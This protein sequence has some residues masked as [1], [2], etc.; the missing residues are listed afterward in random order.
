M[1]LLCGA[2]LATRRR[3]AK[4]REW[5]QS[6]ADLNLRLVY[7]YSLLSRARR[8][9]SNSDI[10]YLTLLYRLLYAHNRYHCCLYPHHLT[11]LSRARIALSTI[12]P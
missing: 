8:R 3:R 9:R 7:L 12:A 6:V 2:C 11:C 4:K 5:N 10:L 1:L